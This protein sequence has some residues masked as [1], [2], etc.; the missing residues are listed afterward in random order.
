MVQQGSWTLFRK[1]PKAGI[2][3]GEF[4]LKGPVLDAE[5]ES[6]FHHWRCISLF[7]LVYHPSY[8]RFNLLIIYYFIFCYI[9]LSQTNFWL[10]IAKFQKTQIMSN[11]N[12]PRWLKLRLVVFVSSSI[13]NSVCFRFNSER[14]RHYLF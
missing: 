10:E 6:S 9:W 5:S 11:C 2:W 12:C 7:H 13:F 8:I 4:Q 14:G 1:A 3:L